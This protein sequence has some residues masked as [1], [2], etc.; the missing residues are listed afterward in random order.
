AARYAMNIGSR[1]APRRAYPTREERCNRRGS[2]C[3]RGRRDRAHAAELGDQLLVGVEVGEHDDLADLGVLIAIA[4]GRG[5]AAPPARAAAS[6]P[7]DVGLA[8][9][10]FGQRLLLGGSRVDQRQGH[11]RFALLDVDPA[12]QTADRSTPAAEVAEKAADRRSGAAAAR[13]LVRADD[14]RLEEI[15]RR[16]DLAPAHVRAGLQLA[17]VGQRALHVAA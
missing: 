16:L 14:V 9:I 4:S 2:A 1:S 13:I 12:D 3:R 10:A 11:V 15:I 6:A 17:A 5:E 7:A 8:R